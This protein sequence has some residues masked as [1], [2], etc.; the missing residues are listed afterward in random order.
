MGKHKHLSHSQ[1]EFSRVVGKVSWS[2]TQSRKR[3]KATYEQQGNCKSS[4]KKKKQVQVWGIS[5]LGG[6]EDGDPSPMQ[7]L[8]PPNHICPAA[9]QSPAPLPKSSFL[10][11][12]PIPIPSALPPP[13]VVAWFTHSPL[14]W[15]NAV[16]HLDF[17][18]VASSSLPLL[19]LLKFPL[20]P[21]IFR[22]GGSCC[23]VSGY[24]DQCCWGKEETEPEREVSC[25]CRD[26]FVCLTHLKTCFRDYA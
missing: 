11:V 22:D 17:G 1:A 9:S 6:L 10:A 12:H 16:G 2:E 14:Q 8:S 23:C 20:F 13:H 24:S 5:Y 15:Q 26:T 7:L 4:R 25:A 19:N 3:P 21:F 18:S